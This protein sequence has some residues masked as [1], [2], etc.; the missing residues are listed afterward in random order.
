MKW[1]C[2]TEMRTGNRSVRIADSVRDLVIDFDARLDEILEKL[3]RI[4]AAIGRTTAEAI[5]NSSHD[6]DTW[7][8]TKQAAKILGIATST[9]HKDRHVKSCKFPYSKVG[10]I[11]RY[12]IGDL[13]K[14]MEERKIMDQNKRRHR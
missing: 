10:G 4:E 13:I 3:E 9:L 12:N 14:L 8:D 11:I 2:V 5:G 6:P 7:V 1:G